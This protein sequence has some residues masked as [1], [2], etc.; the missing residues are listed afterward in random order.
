MPDLFNVTLLC[1]ETRSPSL[2]L[3]AM[4][5]CLNQVRFAK[6]ILI[7]D[8]AIDYV[9]P[10]DIEV[11]A[12]PHITKVDDYS[13]YILSDLTPLIK[14]GHVLIMQWDSF[15]TNPKSWIDIFLHYD[16]IGAPW[17]HHP[18]TPVGNGGFSLRSVKLI[19]A[20]QN[21]KINKRHPEDQCICIDN[22]LLLEKEFGI[23]FAPL[24]IANKFSVER[25]ENF[26]AFGMHGVFNFPY[27]LN[28]LELKSVIQIIPDSFLGNLDT[29]DLIEAL[30]KKKHYLLCGNVLKRTPIKVKFLKKYLRYWYQ[31]QHMRL[32][33][34]ILE[35]KL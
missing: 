22:R 5:R 34:F 30:L 25:G 19:Q 3:W 24:E 9:Y 20:I 32:S 1:V 18:E 15:I 12:A 31:L 28:Y 13:L 23:K 2:A 11:I 14:G 21:K 6:A 26:S 35:I 7:T 16:Y 8:L 17:P 27:F 33:K 29:Y 10:R 4:R